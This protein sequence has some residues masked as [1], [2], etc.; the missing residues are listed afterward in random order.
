MSAAASRRRQPFR[1]HII[2]GGSAGPAKPEADIVMECIEY[3]PT[4]P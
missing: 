4:A 2:T 1:K 3:Q